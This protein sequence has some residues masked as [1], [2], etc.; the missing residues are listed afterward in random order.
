MAVYR[1]R[2]GKWVG[3]G[4]SVAILICRHNGSVFMMFIEQQNLNTHRFLLPGLHI[5][6]GAYVNQ[7]RFFPQ[8]Q[9]PR[10]LEK[11]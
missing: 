5:L 2:E 11:C 4:L 3:C 10:K 7:L 6:A 8:I 1:G 9:W